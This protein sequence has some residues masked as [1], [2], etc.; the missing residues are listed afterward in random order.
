MNNV[1]HEFGEV[2]RAKVRYEPFLI[3]RGERPSSPNHPRMSMVHGD[4][5]ILIE[6]K[7]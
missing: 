5:P 4:V 6:S 1:V 3:L 2:E 7:Y